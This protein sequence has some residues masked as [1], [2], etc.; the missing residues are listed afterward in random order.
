VANTYQQSVL[1][2]E[3]VVLEQRGISLTAPGSQGYLGV[4]AFHA[5]LITDLIPGKL[6]LKDEHGKEQVMAVSGGFLEISDNRA[7]I[8]ADAIERP[9]EIDV[10]RAQKARER[11]AERLRDTRGAWDVERAR[12]SL[13]R[14]LNRLRVAV[15]VR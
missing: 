7:T 8:L 4:L 13:L 12:A 6:T 15:E 3:R 2:P 5:P 10:E 14:A 9:D 1:T 11:A